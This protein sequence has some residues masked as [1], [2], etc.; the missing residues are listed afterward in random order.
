MAAN[1]RDPA[2]LTTMGD[3]LNR[4]AW[5]SINPNVNVS[6]PMQQYQQMAQQKATENKTLEWLK[7]NDPE[8]YQYAQAGLPVSDV[9]KYAMQK[10]AEA[11]KPKDW[12]DQYMVA[13]GNIYGAPTAPGE[14]PRL[15]AG[16]QNPYK[17]LPASAQ[18]AIW[19]QNATPEEKKAWMDAKQASKANTNISIN[20]GEDKFR[21]ELAK[22]QAEM[23]T[24]MAKDGMNAKADLAL[25]Q[26]LDELMRGKG[27]TFDGV[28]LA[29]SKYG[30]G[31]EGVSDL[32]AIDATISKLVPSQRVPGSGTTSDRDL[33]LFKASLPSLWNQPG[34]NQLILSTM[35]GLAQ[36]KAAQGEIA[37]R[38]MMNQMTKEEAQQALLS[39]PD[40]LAE[41][42]QLVKSN[43]N[44]VTTG[45]TSFGNTWKLLPEQQ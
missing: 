35:R 9:M 43:A 24:N 18:E 37:Q 28:S 11:Q 40:P 19:L 20:N 22:G 38:V 10:R 12:K 32:Q 7:A 23:F 29:L 39:L 33:E 25:V 13:N 21:G 3:T 44:P 26:G 17:G 30:L 1:F 16:D 8:A 15:V 41:F 6:E 42:K 4:M 2:F 34:G 5:A 14:A 31:G 36:Y 27:G 45:K